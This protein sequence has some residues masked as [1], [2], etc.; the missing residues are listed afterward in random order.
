MLRNS[1]SPR[2]DLPYGADQDRLSGKL[3]LLGAIG[4]GAISGAEVAL[5]LT[6]GDKKALIAAGVSG[7]ASFFSGR[8][9]LEASE[10]AGV[11]IGQRKGYIQGQNNLR[12]ELAV[13]SNAAESQNQ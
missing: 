7:V 8:K 2:E 9:A 12:A 3:Y 1:K 13:R 6:G 5:V 4:A 11:A 10:A